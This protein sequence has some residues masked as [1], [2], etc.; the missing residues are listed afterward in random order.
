MTPAGD[1]WRSSHSAWQRRPGDRHSLDK[2]L[3]GDFSAWQRSPGDR[4][5]LDK[6]LMGD[7]SAKFKRDFL[8]NLITV[9]VL[10]EIPRS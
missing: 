1:M 8:N 6:S 2:S 7:F 9:S 5:S 10:A 4:H 3:M